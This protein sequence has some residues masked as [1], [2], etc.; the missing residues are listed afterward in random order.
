MDQINILKTIQLPESITG[1]IKDKFDA[2]DSN[3]NALSKSTYTAGKDG[4]TRV[5]TL[6]FKDGKV[7]NEDKFKDWLT[8]QLGISDTESV[9]Y[10]IVNAFANYKKNDD[11]YANGSY[12]I[13]I[14]TDGKIKEAL[15]ILYAN[16]KTISYLG[17][18]YEKDVLI[19]KPKQ[20]V[21]GI[22]NGGYWIINGIKTNIKAHGEDGSNGVNGSGLDFGFV[23][24]EHA[25]QYVLNNKGKLTLDDEGNLASNDIDKSILVIR[26]YYDLTGNNNYVMDFAELSETKRKQWFDNNRD[27][28][29]L[30]TY[31]EDGKGSKTYIGYITKYDNTLKYEYYDEENKKQTINGYIYPYQVKD[32]DGNYSWVYNVDSSLY[33]FY[34]SDATI[35][36]PGIGS[37]DL[38]T[39]FDNM[40]FDQTNSQKPRGIWF[41]NTEN[42]DDAIF[43]YNDK[44]ILNIGKIDEYGRAYNTGDI[45]T[46]ITKVKVNGSFECDGATINGT[47][48]TDNLSVGKQ[49]NIGSTSSNGE[50]GVYGSIRINTNGDDNAVLSIYNGSIG[51]TSITPT[52]ITSTNLKLLGN[53]AINNNLIVGYI[54]ETKLTIQDESIYSNNINSLKYRVDNIT[55]IQYDLFK[56]YCDLIDNSYEG[57]LI[58]RNSKDSQSTTITPRKIKTDNIESLNIDVNTLNVNGDIISGNDIHA[59]ISFILDCLGDKTCYAKLSYN[60]TRPRLELKKDNDITQIFPDYIKTNNVKSKKFIL[61]KQDGSDEK[62][63]DITNNKLSF[64]F[65]EDGQ[66]KYLN[67]AN[68][69]YTILKNHE[70]ELNP[71]DNI[72]QDEKDVTDSLFSQNY[73]N[74]ILKSPNYDLCI[75]YMGPCEL[76]YIQGTWTGLDESHAKGYAPLYKISGFLYVDLNDDKIVGQFK[77]FKFPLKYSSNEGSHSDIYNESNVFLIEDYFT[78]L[79]NEE[80]NWIATPYGIDGGHIVPH[81]ENVIENNYNYDLANMNYHVIGLD[82]LTGGTSNNNITRPCI[83]GLYTTSSHY[84]YKFL[85]QIK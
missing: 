36:S 10:S 1:T 25:K 42:G 16:D 21:L 75:K 40:R 67:V 53:A 73:E 27:K 46:D 64:S 68:L 72:Q 6:K 41:R 84:L 83:R 5:H 15:P 17:F 65:E 82:N 29:F 44:N 85:H 63:V 43:M 2:I 80:T 45:E 22:D 19:L 24:V 56:L 33:G 12:E 35:Y 47:T 79:K 34:Y 51:G 55:N 23:T 57:T 39:F 78:F 70:I 26:Q 61:V 31:K 59:Q 54:P 66:Y 32:E 81:Y 30:F 18:E 38:I 9:I 11:W 20:D 69:Y 7:N 3:F 48:I 74:F 28:V 60:S 62:S 13:Y 37:N 50:L 52:K 14:G 71:I 58:L 4:V 8:S 49:I 76:N 77:N